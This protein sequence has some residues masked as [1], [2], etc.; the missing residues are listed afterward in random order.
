ME[1]TTRGGLT[2]GEKS[3]KIVDKWHKLAKIGEKCF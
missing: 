1:N 3:G 2:S